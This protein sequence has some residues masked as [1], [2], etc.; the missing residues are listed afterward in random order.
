MGQICEFGQGA[1]SRGHYPK[2]DFP[3]FEIFGMFFFVRPKNNFG[4]GGQEF[5]NS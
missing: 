1:L 4:G 2:M 5:V 3:S